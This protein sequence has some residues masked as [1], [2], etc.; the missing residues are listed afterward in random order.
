M[1]TGQ[2]DQDYIARSILFVII[3]IFV[4]VVVALAKFTNVFSPEVHAI[5]SFFGFVFSVEFGVGFVVGFIVCA[6]VI[7]KLKD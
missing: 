1:A 4:V 2:E 3:I 5:S 6:L 7:L